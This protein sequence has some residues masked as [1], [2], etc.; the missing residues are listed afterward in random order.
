MP[1]PIVDDASRLH[2]LVLDSM[3]EGVSL[4]DENGVIGYTNPAE[5]A[6][7]GYAPGELVGQH[8]TVQNAYP[9]EENARIVQEVIEQL[10]TAGVWSGEWRNRRKDGTTFITSARIT[11]VD[12]GGRKHWVCVQKDISREQRAQETLRM[13]EERYRSLVQAT[14]AIVWQTP[15]TGEMQSDQRAWGEFTGQSGEDMQQWGWLAAIHPD[16]RAKTRNA[17]ERALATRSPYEVEHR[18]RR[19][20]GEYRTMLARAVPILDERGEVRDWVGLHTDLTAKRRLQQLLDT[21]RLRLRDIFERAPAFIATLAGPAHVFETANPLYLELVGNRDIIGKTVREALPE[22][23]G[24][25]F[26]ELLDD[27]Y[28]T[29]VA[30]VADGMRALLLRNGE[31]DERFVNF[32]YEPLRD[33]DGN[34]NGIFVHGNDVTAVHRTNRELQYQIGLTTTITDNAASCLF[35]MDERGHPTFMNPA[36]VEVTG[37]TLE[38]I[39]GEPL[40]FAVHHHHPDGRPYPIADCPIDN[41]REQ[42]V[43][44]KDYRDVFVRKDGTFFPVSCYVAPFERDGRAA[45]AVLEFRDITADVR[46]Q[47]LLR[48]ADRRKDEFLA[49][50]SHELRTPLTA[51]LGWAHMLLQDRTDPELVRGGLETIEKSARLQAELIDDVLDLSRITAGKVRINSE[52]VDIGAVATAAV[53]GVRL[54]AAAKEIDLAIESSGEPAL[55]LGDAHRLQQILWN[56]L[57]NAIKFTPRGGCVQLLI[58]VRERTIGVTVSDTGIGIGP[59]FLPH[60]FE[61]F[62]QAESTTTRAHGGL[63]LGLSIVRHLVELHGGYVRAESEGE[64][65]GATFVI[66]LP[67]LRSRGVPVESE[68]EHGLFADLCGLSVL[69]IDD[70]QAVRELLVALLQ[71]GGAEVRAASSAA[72]GRERVEERVPDAILC[73]IAMP[74]EDGYSFVRWLRAQPEASAV[75]VI[76]VTAFGGAEDEQQILAA[77]FDSYI[78]KPIEP[79]ALSRVVATYRRPL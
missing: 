45:G 21:E 44:L 28:R 58:E 33:T 31:E 47:E 65:L 32:V 8:V 56:L 11:A 67:R 18:L 50:L 3:S 48:Q 49:T 64:G 35:M 79:T 62:R 12:I 60:V 4:S 52:T 72:E 76:A 10:Q 25:G 26:Y 36:A 51:I 29:G 5:D 75:P 39:R 7:F 77:D 42:L 24:Q 74:H 14:A 16:D 43:A 61:P 22:I 13:S 57:T 41:G 71:R 68:S 34:V 1:S 78:R 27:V 55:I 17:W 38:E 70:Q 37:Y 54:A 19:H 63:G 59:D 23:E 69:V 53:E 66:E 15:A 6:M 73:D 46:A 20:D 30:Y 9:P 2:Q 40:H